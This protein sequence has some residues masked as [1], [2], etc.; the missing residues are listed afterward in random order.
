MGQPAIYSEALCEKMMACVH[1]AFG[2]RRSVFGEGGD[3][4]GACWAKRRRK[5]LKTGADDL[6]NEQSCR[7]ARVFSPYRFAAG[8]RHSRCRLY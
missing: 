3:A 8:V 4:A 5:R 1:L 6:Q 2:V 7:P